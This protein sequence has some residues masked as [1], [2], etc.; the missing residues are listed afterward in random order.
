MNLKKTALTDGS[1]RIHALGVGDHQHGYFA[2]AKSFLAL[3]PGRFIVGVKPAHRHGLD[4]TD[5]RHR[6]R[7]IAHAIQFPQAR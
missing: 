1:D 2:V 7:L 6:H 4:M 5:W 3:L